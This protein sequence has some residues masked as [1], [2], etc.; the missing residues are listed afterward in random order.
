MVDITPEP[1][2][3]M[4]QIISSICI[5]VQVQQRES[6]AREIGFTE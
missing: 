1:E 6:N 3:R 2:E 4:V 5:I